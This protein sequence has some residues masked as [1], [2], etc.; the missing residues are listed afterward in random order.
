[1]KKIVRVLDDDFRSTDW[2]IEFR[3]FITVAVFP[4]FFIIVILFIANDEDPILMGVLPGWLAW[5]LYTSC[6]TTH[7][8]R[9]K[10]IKNI[11]W[12]IE[13]IDNLEEF[14][15]SESRKNLV[16]KHGLNI[17]EFVLF[18]MIQRLYVIFGL[19]LTMA[20]FTITLLTERPHL[21]ENQLIGVY[22]M[23]VI[24]VLT[25]FTM[26]VHADTKIHFVNVFSIKK[27]YLWKYTFFVFIS[28]MV[29]ATVLYMS[30]YYLIR[31]ILLG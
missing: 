10:N 5:L 4:A 15:P 2:K 11:I 30:I 6:M 1:M 22:V 12:C 26:G 25:L 18:S 13:P 21:A 3:Y 16:L 8:E 29:F 27:K 23:G 7:E 20:L 28:C 31:M 19:L 14:T 9:K 24:F 17:R